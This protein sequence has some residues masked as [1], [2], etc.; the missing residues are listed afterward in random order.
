MSAKPEHTP[1]DDLNDVLS[2]PFSPEQ[3][4]LD[5]KKWLSFSAEEADVARA[6]VIKANR[7]HGR[8]LST[9]Q[10]YLKGVADSRAAFAAR[11]TLQELLVNFNPTEELSAITP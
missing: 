7:L 11:L 2:A 6:A 8:P 1:N 5:D 9:E 4:E 3:D 10:A